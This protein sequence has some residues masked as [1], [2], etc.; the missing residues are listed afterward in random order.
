MEL[1]DICIITTGFQ[2]EDKFCPAKR[3]YGNGKLTVFGGNI[4]MEHFEEIARD[5]AD[6]NPLNG[7]GTWTKL[8]WFGHMDQQD[9]SSVF[10]ISAALGLH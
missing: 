7:S 4:F 3:E 9:Y 1:L 5:T 8:S 6:H 2:F 10:N